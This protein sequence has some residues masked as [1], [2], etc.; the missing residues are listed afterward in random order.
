[1]HTRS[2][3][4][5]VHSM[6][7]KLLTVRYNLS[8]KSN[9]KKFK[10][11]PNV[12]DY[13]TFLFDNGLITYDEVSS[14]FSIDQDGALHS[15]ENSGNPDLTH[16]MKLLV[17][18]IMSKVE[19]PHANMPASL[20]GTHFK[21][22]E[23]VQKKH[24]GE[25]QAPRDVAVQ[26]AK[27]SDMGEI[28]PKPG[29]GGAGLYMAGSSS[30]DPHATHTGMYV[31]G[32]EFKPY[33]DPYTSQDMAPYHPFCP[34]TAP[35]M[36]VPNPYMAQMMVPNPHADVSSGITCKNR[37][38]AE[39]KKELSF[40]EKFLKR[41]KRDIIPVVKKIF[42]CTSNKKPVKAAAGQEEEDVQEPKN[43]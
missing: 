15:A 4:A 17:E 14:T 27:K 6:L 38:A 32:Y 42:F 39:E 3:N 26:A 18:Y 22:Q 30:A 24:A 20:K 43:P 1:M 8:Q 5:M 11:F 12:S 34:Y 13:S 31:K 33:M 9:D 36:M 37:K 21:L 41:I 7:I 2:I 35:H 25:L 29:M 19:D 40:S 16:D 28:H 10:L 23:A